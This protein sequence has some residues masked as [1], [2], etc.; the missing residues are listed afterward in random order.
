MPNLNI[1]SGTKRRIDS[2]KPIKWQETPEYLNAWVDILAEYAQKYINNE[3]MKVPECFLL[4]K[5]EMIDLNDRIQVFIDAKLVFGTPDDKVGK[6]EMIEL[7]KAFFGE[8]G[9]ISL[10]NLSARLSEKG[11]PYNSERNVI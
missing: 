7:H 11:I 3:I 5:D 10:Q 2:Y 9:N 8:S 1:D 6:F 4:A